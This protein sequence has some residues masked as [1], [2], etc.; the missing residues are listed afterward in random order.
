MKSAAVLLPQEVARKA[1][2]V[3]LETRTDR[4]DWSAVTSAAELWRDYADWCEQRP[5]PASCIFTQ[6]AFGLQL[7]AIG[8]RNSKDGRG[9][10]RWSGVAL[11]SAGEIIAA[12]ERTVTDSCSI[13]PICGGPLIGLFVSEPSGQSENSMRAA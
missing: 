12:D 11:K 5:L 10:R 4:S 9:L 13:C 7:R 6:C 3:W 8:C 2:L 1:F